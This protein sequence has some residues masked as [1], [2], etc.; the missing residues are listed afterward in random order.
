MLGLATL[1]TGDPVSAEK[2]LRKALE[3]GQAP[4]QALPPL[5]RAMLNSVRRKDSAGA[6]ATAGS[7]T[8]GRRQDSSLH[9]GRHNCNWAV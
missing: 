8:P 7:R 5:A 1:R 9:S 2:E 4:E 6:S 3:L